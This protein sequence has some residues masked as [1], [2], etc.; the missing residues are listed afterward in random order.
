MN[1]IELIGYLASL[2][3][4]VSLTM[5][6]I[7]RLR[8]MNLFGALLFATYGLL[9]RAYPVFAVNSFIAVID[10]YYLI[11]MATQRD[12]FSYAEIEGGASRLLVKFIDFYTADIAR[13]FPSFDS[14]SLRGI[15]AFFVLRNLLPVGLFIYEPLAGGEIEIK[16]DYVIPDYRDLKN[17]QFLFSAHEHLAQQ[18]FR[19]WLA[20]STV[21]EH[22]DYLR[23]VGFVAD[24]GSPTKFRKS[25]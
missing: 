1:P 15:R 14:T 11:Q 17:A 5:S 18:G 20:E 10:I 3:V 7:W 4:A 25:L 13:F 2:L 6:N 8:W 9:V 24:K 16:L 12:F 23:R 22:Q 19:T 21:P